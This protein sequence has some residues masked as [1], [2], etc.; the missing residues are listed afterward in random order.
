MPLN[1]RKPNTLIGAGYIG[2]AVHGEPMS[3]SDFLSNFVATVAGGALLTFIFFF[4][5]EKVFPFPDVAG[6]WFFQVTTLETAYNPYK[7]MKLQYVAVIWR[8]GSRVRGT[9]EKMHETSSTGERDYVGKHHDTGAV[10]VSAE[11]ESELVM[12]SPE[13]RAEYLAGLGV[14]ETGVSN[15]I[16][17]AYQ[18]L[19]LRTYLTTGEKETRAWTIHAG[20]KAPQAAGVIHSDFEKSFISAEVASYDDLVAA[21]SFARARELGKLRTEGKEYVMQDG[22]VVEFK[23]FL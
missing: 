8:E 11:I 20:D 12:L 1:S 7:N 17:E 10:V 15:L 21:G 19:G 16:R 18:L 4:L 22:D 14:T 5:K 6:M 3:L 2:D 9:V 13:E 23:T